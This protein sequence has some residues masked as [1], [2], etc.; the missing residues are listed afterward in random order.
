MKYKIIFDIAFNELEIKNDDIQHDCECTITV[1][2][3]KELLNAFLKKI[4]GY[5][6]INIKEIKEL[7]NSHNEP[8]SLS[9]GL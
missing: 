3:I 9:K 6:Y 5:E 8:I 2:N 4:K 1:D 7:D